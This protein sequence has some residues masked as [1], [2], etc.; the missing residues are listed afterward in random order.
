MSL[1]APDL[2]V[3]PQ[4]SCCLPR[5]LSRRRLGVGGWQMAW[6]TLLLGVDKGQQ[7]F[8]LPS[9]G[10]RPK[11]GRQWYSHESLDVETPHWKYRVF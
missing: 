10:N 8:S 4:W 3:R 9:L 5:P 11:E 7:D 2:S 6:A 1:L